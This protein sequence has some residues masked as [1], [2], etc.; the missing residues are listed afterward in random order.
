MQQLAGLL[1]EREEFAFEAVFLDRTWS[2][3][4]ELRS[5]LVVTLMSVL[6]LVR[7]GIAS[8]HQPTDAVALMVQRRGSVEEAQRALADY[9]EA[10]SFG[11]PVRAEDE[12]DLEPAADAPEAASAEAAAEGPPE[13]ASEGPAD[14]GEWDAR[15]LDELGAFEQPSPPDHVTDQATEAAGQ[16]T[17]QAAGQAAGGDDD[18]LSAE[19]TAADADAPEPL[20]RTP[21]LTQDAAADAPPGADASEPPTAAAKPDGGR[22]SE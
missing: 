21:G 14:D 1:F 3:E 11:A 16:A 9:D 8:V 10:L 22:H 19:S 17:D 12:A 7:L 18:A 2:S 6:E 4:S 20:A 13:A 5:M 15:V